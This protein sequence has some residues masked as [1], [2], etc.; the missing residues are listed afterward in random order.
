MDIYFL[1]STT[2]IV[3]IYNLILK[4]MHVNIAYMQ[5]K[6]TPAKPVRHSVNYAIFAFRERRAVGRTG[7]RNYSRIRKDYRFALKVRNDICYFCKTNLTL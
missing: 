5:I 6:F 1:V 7:Q 4:Y 2:A 3:Q